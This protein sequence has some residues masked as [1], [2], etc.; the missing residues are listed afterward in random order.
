MDR[1]TYTVGWNC[2]VQ[3]E[4][5]ELL[6]D[7]R[8]LLSSFRGV[9]AIPSDGSEGHAPLVRIDPHRASSG[10]TGSGHA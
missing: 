1:Q 2:A 9:T 7:Q 8:P 3:T 4:S 10:V 6:D 5:C